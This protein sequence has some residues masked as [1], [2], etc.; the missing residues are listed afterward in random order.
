M[1][2]LLSP[3][4]KTPIAFLALWLAGWTAGGVFA[5]GAFLW[6]LG[7]RELLT[8]NSSPLVHRVEA[9]GLGRTRIYSAAKIKALRA[10][11]EAVVGFSNHQARM[12]P[13]LGPSSGPLAFDYGARTIRSAPSMDEAE[14]KDLVRQLAA[15]FPSAAN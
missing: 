15:S 13:F 12:P 11:Q 1:D 7:G 4:E 10:T 8:V 2:Q 3:S 14:A 5:V 9:F 6:Q